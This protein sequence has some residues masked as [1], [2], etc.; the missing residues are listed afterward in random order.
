MRNL[1]PRRTLIPQWDMPSDPVKAVFWFL[2]WSLRVL[3]RFFYILIIGAVVYE[4]IVNGL[5]GFAGTLLVGLGVWL[6]LAVLL[7]FV[8]VTTGV[9]RVFSE[10]NRLQQNYP[11][12]AQSPFFNFTEPKQDRVVE[13]TITDLE[14]ERKKR[15]GEM[16]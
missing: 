5:V 15:R 11:P 16:G 14:E 3:V 13:G 12:R 6:G 8:N 10:V 2:H 4:S 1:R 7:F 9:S